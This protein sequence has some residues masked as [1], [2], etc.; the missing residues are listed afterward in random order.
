MK[1]IL[2]G[3]HASD[4]LDTRF[5]DAKSVV[6]K[7]GVADIRQ[8]GPGPAEAGSQTFRRPAVEVD[9]PPFAPIT[10]VDAV[11][12]QS[13]RPSLSTR[14]WRRGFGGEPPDGSGEAP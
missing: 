10:K 3:N 2:L 14:N 8:A 6:V 4:A 7:A 5:N 12:L 13:A 1:G 11:S 9:R